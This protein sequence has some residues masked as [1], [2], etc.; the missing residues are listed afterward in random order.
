MSMDFLDDTD[1]WPEYETVRDEIK[2]L[3]REHEEL[4]QELREAESASESH[5][6]G[7]ELKA[8]VVELRKRLLEIER[9]LD[10]TLTMY[11]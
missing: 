4:V 1:D 5:P 7:E 2:R 9:K 3:D 11:R 8:K 6:A 10:A